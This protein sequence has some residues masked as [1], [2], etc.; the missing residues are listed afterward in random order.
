MTTPALVEARG[1]VRILLPKNHPNSTAAFRAGAPVTR[2]AVRSFRCKRPKTTISGSTKICFY[3]ERWMDG[4]PTINP[5]HTRAA[6]LPRTAALRR[7]IF[8]FVLKMYLE[9]LFFEEENHPVPS[10]ALGEARGSVTLLLTKNHPVPTPAFRTAAPD[11][12]I[13]TYD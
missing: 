9:M 5:P 8:I 10:P 13:L 12:E 4:L 3:M 1:S 11:L 2:W 6:H 7:R